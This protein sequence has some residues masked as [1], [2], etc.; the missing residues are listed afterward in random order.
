MPTVQVCKRVGVQRA[1]STVSSTSSTS[2]VLPPLDTLFSLRQPTTDDCQSDSVSLVTTGSSVVS[3]M[4]STSLLVSVLDV[5]NVCF[6]SRVSVNSSVNLVPMTSLSTSSHHRPHCQPC[7]I[8]DLT[9][10][11]F[12]SLTS[13]STLS[14]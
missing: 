10:H 13:L 9:V 4:F 11:L 12:L 2:A 7:P 6:L 5:V 14:R 3:S 8:S 1:G